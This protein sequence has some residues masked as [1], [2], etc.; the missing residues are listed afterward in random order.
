MINKTLH[1]TLIQEKKIL[2]LNIVTINK[3]RSMHLEKFLELCI[4]NKT[5]NIEFSGSQHHFLKKVFHE[6]IK[7][8]Q[9]ERCEWKM[10]KMEFGMLILSRWWCNQKPTAPYSEFQSS[11]C[12][13]LSGATLRRILLRAS[14]KSSF[15][16]FRT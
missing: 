7:N 6:L 10:I 13:K 12:F 8:W 16:M 11:Y 3:T 1:N 4:G 9:N 15:F 2:I 5:L 14:S